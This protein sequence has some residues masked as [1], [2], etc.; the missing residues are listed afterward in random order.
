V[1][2]PLITVNHSPGLVLEEKFSKRISLPVLYECTIVPVLQ[3][4]S[5]RFNAA[6]LRLLT[7]D[8]APLVWSTFIV[9][10]LFKPVQF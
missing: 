3:P 8:F 2:L 1:K 10:T 5:S 9:Q 6:P 4:F 7:N